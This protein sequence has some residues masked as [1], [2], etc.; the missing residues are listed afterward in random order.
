MDHSVVLK[1]DPVQEQFVT[2]PKMDKVVS[3][4][5]VFSRAGQPGENTKCEGPSHGTSFRSLGAMG[6]PGLWKDL[7]QPPAL[8]QRCPSG[9]LETHLCPADSSPLAQS[10]S[11][12]QEAN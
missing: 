7:R 6:C 9:G 4:C 12:L 10:T 2:G 1:P 5:P 8:V 11:K 3:I